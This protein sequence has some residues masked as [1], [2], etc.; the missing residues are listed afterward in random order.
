[1][2]TWQG[3]INTPSSSL[4]ESFTSSLLQDQVLARYDIR[5]S[6][7]HARALARAKLITPTEADQLV[8]SLVEV[9]DEIESGTM[10]WRDELEDV[11]THVEV[12][13]REKLGDLASKLHTGRSRND[14]I[15]ADLR[16][17]V[18]DN[19]QSAMTSLLEL[20]SALLNLA[21]RYTESLM[22][23]YSHLHQA[24]PV[25]IAYPLLAY[26]S[27]LG[28]DFERF[29]DGLKRTCRSP[30]GS[31]AVAGSS[32]PIDRTAIASDAGLGQPIENSLDAVSDR[33]FVVE[34]VFDAALCMTHLSRLAEDLIIWSS[35][36]FGFIRLP[37]AFASGSSMMPQ[38]KNPDVL[39]LTRGRCALVIGDAMA[40]LS[41]VKGLPTGYNRDLQEDKQPL[42]HATRTIKATL[43][44]LASM[45]PDL[46]FDTGRCRD[47]IS[48]FT[49]ATDL[50]EHLVRQGVPFRNAHQAVG[51]LVARRATDGLPLESI[52]PEDLPT[53]TPLHTMPD[54]SPEAS[55]RRKATA[56]STHPDDVRRQLDE[57]RERIAQ[58]RK[59]M[60]STG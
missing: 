14:Q 29:H 24:Q 51:T 42:F 19:T 52:T 35:A 58:R 26:V 50:A 23:G 36:E 10:Q 13:L 11:H 43:A 32:F 17:F 31:G 20:Q 53:G 5:V 8:T 30:L 44:I 15:A 45:V 48:S 9:G 41:L 21:D 25:V 7:A 39:E 12:R 1:M 56:G 55:V 33:D 46:E 16:L 34:Y 37:D 22:P 2:K 4:F 60:E 28:R 27:M 38:K 3:R 59:S 47:A 49:I 57:A 18:L 54:L 6:Q 40:M